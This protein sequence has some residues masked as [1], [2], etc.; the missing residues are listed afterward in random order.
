MTFRQRNDDARLLE[1]SMTMPK[2][3]R[4]LMIVAFVAGL[5]DG[6]ETQ[7]RSADWP[8][9]RGPNRDGAAASF[10]EPQTWPDKLTRRWKV[11]VGLGYASP[12]VVGDRIYQFSRQ[13]GDEVMSALDAESGKVLWRTA[14]PAR[15]TMNPAAAPHGEGP[16][17][18]P[19]FANGKLYSIGM[20]GIVTAFDAATGRQL[21]QKPASPVA[22]LYTT[23]SFSPLVDRGLVIFH[24]GG[25]NQGALTA[26]DANTGDVKWRWTGDGPAYASPIVADFDGTRQ[27]VTFTQDNLIGVDAATGALLWKRAYSV[28]YT[29]NNITP[30]LYNQTLIV[31]GLEQPV[32]AL[33]V[34]H[35]GGRWDLQNVWENKDVSLSMSNAVVVRDTLFGMSARKSG[36]FFALD[37]KSGKTLWTGEPRQ[38]TNA[39]IVRAGDILF[40]LKDNAELVVARANPARFEPLRTYSVADSATWAQPTVSGKRLFVKDVSWLTL[41]TVN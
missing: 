28:P 3:C 2:I 24:V 36:Q 30:I 15:F 27:V 4:V 1:G 6:V 29:Q 9:W 26:F 16:K 31:S 23:H 35:Q 7:S 37:A 10:E 39:A 5:T 12:L 11:E 21:W 20:T 19:A 38:G 13:G 18:T 41:W 40:L 17:S 32:V 34:V 14:Y 8:Q 25:H 33:R 22:T